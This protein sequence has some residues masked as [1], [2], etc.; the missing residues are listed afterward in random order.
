[1]ADNSSGRE[2]GVGHESGFRVELPAAIQGKVK[3]VSVKPARFLPA[4]K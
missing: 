2:S 3:I 1:M 4:N